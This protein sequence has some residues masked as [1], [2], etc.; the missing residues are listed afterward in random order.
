MDA[1]RADRQLGRA[2][3]FFLG[4]LPA[5]TRGPS[6]LHGTSGSGSGRCR[7]ARSLAP[8][9]AP[10]GGRKPVEPAAVRL[11][12]DMGHAIRAAEPT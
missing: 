9:A 2:M 12:P 7:A 1:E 11:P 6:L 3:D 5:A 10:A 4:S 8:V